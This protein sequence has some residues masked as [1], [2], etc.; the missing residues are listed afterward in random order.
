MS[1]FRKWFY[2]SIGQL[3]ENVRMGYSRPRNTLA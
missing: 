2:K 3:I 1:D